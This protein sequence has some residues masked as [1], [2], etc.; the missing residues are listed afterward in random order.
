VIAWATETGMDRGRIL[1]LRWTELDLDRADGRIVA[2]RFAMLRGKTGKPIRQVLS[3]GAL[4]R[5]AKLRHASG[6]VFLD[7]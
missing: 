5:A 1:S 4:N 2:D 7:T 3:V 6:V